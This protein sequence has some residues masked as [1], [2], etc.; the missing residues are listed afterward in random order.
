VFGGHSNTNE[1]KNKIHQH[2]TLPT[3]IESTTIQLKLNNNITQIKAVYKISNA[4]LHHSDLNN[5]ITRHNGLF[6]IAGKL[7]SK[8][9]SWNSLSANTAGR[10]LLRHSEA[11][12]TQL[13]P[14]T[15]R[16]IIHTPQRIGQ[17]SLI[18]NYWLYH[19]V[20]TQ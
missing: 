11:N 7:N 17:T 20:N 9:P 12:I 15:L 8:R 19:Q 10:K 16:H 13:M 2:I 3:K 6:I 14:L 1:H 4:Y 5:I 18:L